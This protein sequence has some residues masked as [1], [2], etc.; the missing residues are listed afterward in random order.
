MCVLFCSL[1]LDELNALACGQ[2]IIL[3]IR[4]SSTDVGDKMWEDESHGGDE[5]EDFVLKGMSEYSSSEHDY[6]SPCGR[7]RG[8]G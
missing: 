2:S 5:G 1:R 3:G 7:G 6:D 4:S 8:D